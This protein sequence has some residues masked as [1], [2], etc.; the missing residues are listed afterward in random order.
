MPPLVRAPA[1]ERIARREINFR[2]TH[3]RL[4]GCDGRVMMHRG[5][6]RSGW[7]VFRL[8]AAAAVLFLVISSF[9]LG[10]VI[11]GLIFLV[12]ALIWFFSATP[13]ARK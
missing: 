1:N 10:Y 6:T 7:N 3:L 11:T 13:N 4:V 5:V 9:A 8:L 2:L 12:P